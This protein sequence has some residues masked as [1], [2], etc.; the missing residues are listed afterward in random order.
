[1]P[2]ITILPKAGTAAAIGVSPQVQRAHAQLLAR[3]DLQ[4][5]F[6]QLVYPTV[7]DWLVALLKLLAKIQP[8]LHYLFWVVLSLGALALL[9]LAGREIWR[10]IQSRP[11]PARDL[12]T[13]VREWRPP[14]EKTRQLLQDA[15]K[16]AAVGCYGEAAHLLLLRGIQDIAE[17]RP[18]LLKAALTSREIAVNEELPTAPRSAFGHIA[19]TVERAIFAERAITAEEFA[20][21][22]AEYEQL[23]SPWLLERAA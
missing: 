19:E 5:D 4:F 6:P 8:V 14:D 18:A 23:A 7:P 9:A 13:L 1:M 3:S 15:D 10:R 22:R 21:C 16:L 2:L 20:D 12:R 17:R 11:E